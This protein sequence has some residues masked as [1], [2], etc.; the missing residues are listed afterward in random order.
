MVLI[1]YIYWHYT[2]AP[3][4]ILFLLHNYLIATWHRFLIGTHAKTLL[5]PWHRARPS[6][7]GGARTFGDKI[8]NAIVDFYI[9]II[10]AIIRLVIIL[11]GLLAEVI[12]IAVFMV[13]LVVWLLWPAIFV[14]LISK[15]LV[16][17]Q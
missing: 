13:L 1:D 14:F 17:I 11:I 6:D 16:L 5:S 4:R 15:G 12:L 8:G 3:S 7:V 2:V 10:A 9:R